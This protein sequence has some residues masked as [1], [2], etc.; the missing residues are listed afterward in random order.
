[1]YTCTCVHVPLKHIYVY[2]DICL[3]IFPTH[4]KVCVYISIYTCI[5][6][7]KLTARL[8]GISVGHKKDLGLPLRRLPIQAVHRTMVVV[9][10]SEVSCS[11]VEVASTFGRALVPSI[12]ICH[13]IVYCNGFRYMLYVPP[14][15]VTASQRHNVLR[16]LLGSRGV[17]EG[18]DVHPFVEAQGGQSPSITRQYVSLSLRVPVCIH[19]YI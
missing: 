13:V 5:P 16:P 15:S 11:F 12:R 6:E 1:M 18:P 3:H 19:V 7:S 4:A 10:S 14:P 2:I 17:P 8:P 9:F